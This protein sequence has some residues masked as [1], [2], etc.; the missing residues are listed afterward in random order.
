[1]WVS[2]GYTYCRVECRAKK[3]LSW[4]IFSNY[5]NA[6]AFIFRLR[7]KNK[8]F[9]LGPNAFSIICWGAHVVN[10]N[11]IFRYGLFIWIRLLHFLFLPPPP[12][13]SLFLPLLPYNFKIINQTRLRY[14]R[15][16]RTE[17]MTSKQMSWNW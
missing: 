1:M 12:S 5:L 11:V 16:V 2:L 4:W 8:P 3:R 9:K 6:I 10:S 15:I 7:Q 13:P 17:W 14:F